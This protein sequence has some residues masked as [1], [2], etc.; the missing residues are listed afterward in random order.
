MG[1][2]GDEIATLASHINA[3]TARWLKLLAEFDDRGGWDGYKSCSHWLSWRCGIAPGTAR[4]HVRVAHALARRPLIAAVFERGELSYSKVRALTRLDDDFSEE[5][6]LEYANSASA[7]QLERIVRGCRSCVAVRQDAARRFAERE[8][9]WSYDDEGGVCFR[10][11]L[12]AELGALV[13]RAVEAARDELGPPP[14]EL[15]EDV[16]AE[17]IDQR[18]ATLSPRAR[19]ADAF[20]AVA[21]T[22]LAESASS[23]DV[24]Q[25]VLHVDADALA[26]SAETGAGPDA[27]A[28][29]AETD[30]DTELF[31]VSA[32]TDRDTEPPAVS[33]ETTGRAELEDGEPLPAAAIRRL[34]CDA[35]I[36]RV[37]ENDGRPLSVGRKTRSIPPA[38]QRALRTVYKCCAFPGCNQRYHLDSHHI[39]HW[40][41]G[42]ETKIENLI[43]LCR[44][45]HRLLHEGGFSVRHDGEFISPKGRVI[46]QAPRLPRGDCATVVSSNKARHIRPTA[47][48]LFPADSYG[49]NVDLSWS[50][51][52]LLD[53]RPRDAE[54]CAFRGEPDG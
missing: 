44:H 17:R 28:V 3:A 26:V 47:R 33:A 24:Y 5:L 40:A 37:L 21:Q 52:A 9:S 11:R 49:E 2:L 16:S 35:S 31:A 7:G 4:D 15:A 12:P 38:L 27:R 45:H 8:F 51:E 25:V 6:A 18:E 10:G 46:Q 41:D 19:N 48:S 42:G 13:V 30:G 1:R 22:A 53:T 50:V 23:A 39:D 34:T 32:E 54:R 29:S 20:V 36:V 43:R 14:A